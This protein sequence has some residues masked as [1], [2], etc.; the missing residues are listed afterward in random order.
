M[1]L[2]GIRWLS[3]L[4]FGR[5]VTSLEGW[6]QPALQLFSGDESCAR[7]LPVR[8]VGWVLQWAATL[9]VLAVSAVILIV[10]GYQLAAERALAPGGGG[11]TARSRPAPCDERQRR[12]GRAPAVGGTLAL[13]RATRVSLANAGGRRSIGLAVPLARG[14]AAVVVGV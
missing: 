12:G 6:T 5:R 13:D 11:R 10:F 4:R 8:G 1:E 14:L 2:C 3:Y 7:P 9:M